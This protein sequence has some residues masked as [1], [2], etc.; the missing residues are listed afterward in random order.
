MTK[1]ISTNYHQTI[2]YNKFKGKK[3][4]IIFLSGFMSDMTGQKAITIEN[5]ARKTNHSFLRFD[6]TG[7]GQS[8]GDFNNLVFSD[9]L[10]DSVYIINH[11]TQ[12]PQIIVGSSMGGWIGLNLIKKK[13]VNV[14]SIICLAAAPDFPKLLIWDKLNFSQKKNLIKNKKITLSKKYDGEEYKN[15]FTK[16]FLKDALYNRVMNNKLHFTGKVFLYHGMQ[17]QDVPYQ[18][19]INIMNNI[20]GTNNIQLILE[21]NGKH[22]LS[23]KNELK[24]ILKLLEQCN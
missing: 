4:G 18:T 3:T 13:S 22:R 23:E 6:Y 10:R 24:T 5:W 1:F 20:V 8:S 15:T 11:L 14:K 2:A 19:S 12:G 7:H 16:D 21:K 17:D 9:W